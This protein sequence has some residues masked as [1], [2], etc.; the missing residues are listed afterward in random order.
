VTDDRLIGEQIGPFEIVAVLGRGAFATVY[1]AR[2]DQLDRDVALKVLDPMLARDPEAA[3][4][5]GGEGMRAATLDHRAILPVYAAGNDEDGHHYLAMQLVEG[6]TLA[7]ELTREHR[8][9]PERIL[10]V[11]TPV[12]AALDHAHSR[13]VIH[14][15]VKPANI[16][17]A[18][19]HV[20]LTDF[21]IAATAQTV[22]R[23]TTGALGT[24]AY[25]APEQAQAGDIDGRADLY[26]LGCVA[27]ECVTGRPPYLGDDLVTILLAHRNDP[28]P[29]TGDVA[30][31]AFML[32]ALALDPANRFSSGEEL[33]DALRAAI[34]GTVMEPP[35]SET[36][37]RRRSWLVLAAAALFIAGAI[38]VV[39]HIRSS[40]GGPVA[41][42]TGL[43][44][45]VQV[46]DPNGARYRVPRGW[47]VA[48]VNPDASQYVTQ[49]DANG[50]AV[51]TIEAAPA[52]SA[53]AAD[54]AVAN[55]CPR[56]LQADALLGATKAVFCEFPS[57]RQDV[58][59]VV[60]HAHDWVIAVS[61]DA[62]KSEVDTFRSSFTFD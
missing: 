35:P 11:L 1:R 22:G 60:D 8:L 55:Q 32:H 38:V 21:G 44:G 12:A 10:A 58:F 57:T 13:G 14:R 49:L 23:Y 59:Y 52:Q 31:D 4:R 41:L 27:Y 30:L 26:A 62:P 47:S 3:R 48:A 34:G 33:I 45:P 40:S 43:A 18:G 20:W 61:L 42:R 17:I 5:F 16:L 24:V 39:T 53:T 7:D 56:S 28:V 6:E 15:D 37:P 29:T 50:K 36:P 25:M 19:D 46:R 2:Q 51:A 9:S 54:L